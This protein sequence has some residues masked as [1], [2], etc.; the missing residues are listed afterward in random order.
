MSKKAFLIVGHS[1]RGKSW[2][3]RSL[4][5][6]HSHKNR[7]TLDN[8]ELFV[9][10][11][12]N[13]DNEDSLLRFVKKGIR[14][15]PGDVILTFCPRFERDETKE[16]LDLLKLDFELHFFVLQYQQHPKK[17]GVISDAEIESLK[18]YGAKLEIFSK[19]DLPD[20]IAAKFEK[21][22]KENL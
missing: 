22:V 6:G 18:K 5:E 8:H 13:D 15:K 19:K 11:M 1:N 10:R 3:I 4:I 20:N 16:I 12:S 9:R 14:N 2:T 7:F 17:D 21:F